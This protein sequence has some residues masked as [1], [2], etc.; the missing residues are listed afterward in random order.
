MHNN[1]NHLHEHKIREC[2]NRASLTYDQES[3]VQ[4]M[5][6]DT[7]IQLISKYRSYC[8][9][10]VDL[11]CGTGM[12]TEKLAAKIKYQHFEAIDI[13][14]AFLTLAK[15]RLFFSGIQIYQQDF[16]K[17]YLNH[18][19]Y[20]LVFS[21]MA[22]QWSSDLGKFFFM[23]NQNIIKNGLLVFSLPLV[24]TF[25]EIIQSSRNQFHASSHISDFLKKAGF[26]IDECFSES[27]IFHFDSWIKA[28]KSIKATGA[29]YLFARKHK[30][31]TGTKNHRLAHITSLTY[32]IG[33]FIA[34][35]ST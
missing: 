32:R 27:Y 26:E 35:K 30:A 14:E 17:L 19:L 23:I 29:N 21:N 1:H 31:L 18:R 5:V 34:R 9:S 22:L 12:V 15:K 16:E 24:G 2:F 4:Q 7:L 10:V 6:G 3:I 11:G 33:Y 25:S 13:A 8:E 20:H 28:L